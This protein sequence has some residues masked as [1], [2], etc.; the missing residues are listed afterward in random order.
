MLG[1][2]LGVT[3]HSSGLV[4]IVRTSQAMAD[5]DEALVCMCDCQLCSPSRSYA[6]CFSC[7]CRQAAHMHA[8]KMVAFDVPRDAGLDGKFASRSRRYALPRKGPGPLSPH[9]RTNMLT[10]DVS[11]RTHT[12]LSSHTTGTV[13]RQPDV[14]D[15]WRRL[16]ELGHLP[17]G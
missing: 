6:A 16:V 4:R 3:S 14:N 8:Q 17:I 2:R 10:N 11:R 12:A 5:P 15:Q 13:S 1:R 9:I 7:P